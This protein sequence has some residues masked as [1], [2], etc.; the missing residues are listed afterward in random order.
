M[1][2]DIDEIVRLERF[3][4]QQGTQIGEREVK[5]SLSK[6]LFKKSKLHAVEEF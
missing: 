1:V 5:E 4:G 3:P 2:I 6:E